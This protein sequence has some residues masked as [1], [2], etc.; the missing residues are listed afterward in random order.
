VDA[1]WQRGAI[2]N[3]CSCE[4]DAQR[5]IM[6]AAEGDDLEALL[7]AYQAEADAQAASV[8]ARCVL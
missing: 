5:N 2:C 6:T 4:L 7:D 3:I 1:H 8:E